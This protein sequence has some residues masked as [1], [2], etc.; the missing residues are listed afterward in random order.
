MLNCVCGHVNSAAC[1]SI[2]LTDNVPHFFACR[3][4]HSS[5]NVNVIESQLWGSMSYTAALLLNCILALN[6][7]SATAF[8]IFNWLI[9]FHWKYLLEQQGFWHLQMVTF[10]E[11]LS[12]SQE[13]F[14]HWE[15]QKTHTIY[16]KMHF[17]SVALFK[18]QKQTFGMQPQRHGI[19]FIKWNKSQPFMDHK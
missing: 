2:L 18:E 5:F 6:L 9:W 12:K 8:D 11:S 10:R 14:F 19:C 17:N 7:V 4:T 3:V 15:R 13:A 16:T 1:F